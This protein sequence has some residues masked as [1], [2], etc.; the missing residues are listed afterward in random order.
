NNGSSSIDNLPTLLNL[1]GAE[2]DSRLILGRDILS[3]SAG[4]VLFPDRSY[5]TDTYEYYAALGTIGGD[6]SDETFDAMQLYVA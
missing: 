3:D 1:M 2:Y 6:V 4:L 5:V